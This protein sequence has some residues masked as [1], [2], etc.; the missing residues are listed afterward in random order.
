[1]TRIDRR[2]LFTSGAAAALL[3][4]TGAS[5]QG[6]PRRGGVLRLALPR[7]G[8]M[9]ASVAKGAICD[10]LTGIGPDGVLRDELARTWRS[11]P[12]ARVWHFGLREDAVFHDGTLLTADHVVASLMAHDFPQDR[13]ELRAIGAHELKLELAT[14]NPDLPYLLADPALIIAAEGVVD[15]PLQTLNGTGFYQATD[16]QGDR[17]FRASRVAQ[18]Y[19]DGQAGWVDRVEV[20]TIPDA[21]VR[22]EALRDGFVDV[23]A[24]P[25]PKGL[26]KRGS[27]TYHPSASDM[28]LAAGKGVGLPRRIG[29]RSALDD[30][31][32]LERWWMS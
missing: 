18:N 12:D 19:R 10:T 7:D 3:A 6:A 20:I 32:I 26:L 17:H 22:A 16:V 31:R 9:L 13:L 24:I 15:A 27:F 8:E 14:P 23:A 1:M 28:A 5:A 25:E 4:A 2:A 21:A 11:S 29:A 30:G